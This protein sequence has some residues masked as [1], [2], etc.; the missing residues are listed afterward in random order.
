MYICMCCLILCVVGNQLVCTVQGLPV[1]TFSEFLQTDSSQVKEQDCLWHPNAATLG[2]CGVV[3]REAGNACRSGV[4]AMLNH[5]TTGG[6]IHCGISVDNGTVEEGLELEQS[7]V[8]DELRKT[9]GDATK[10]FWP[11][12][13]SSF[14]QRQA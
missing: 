3:K 7:T 10:T 6:S 8:M 4:N 11:S 9:V 14:V 2:V 5:R 1:S 12:I 13:E